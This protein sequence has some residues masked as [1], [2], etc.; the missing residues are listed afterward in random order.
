MIEP[1]A[2]FGI[3]PF[4][5]QMIEENGGLVEEDVGFYSGLIVSC[6]FLF[7]FEGVGIG[8]GMCMRLHRDCVR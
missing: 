5:N 7:Y 6:W 2:F 3:F 4:V 8:M 1:M